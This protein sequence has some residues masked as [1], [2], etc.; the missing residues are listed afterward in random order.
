MA[1]ILSTTEEALAYL[2]VLTEN[3]EADKKII[4]SGELSKIDI[5]IEGP[6]Y[7]STIPGELARA[8]WEYQEAIY[9]AGAFVLTGSDD[10]RRLSAKQR[11]GLELIFKVEHGS[12]DIQALLEKV[13]E[14]LGEG[15]QQMDDANKAMVLIAITVIFAAGFIAWK[16][17]SATADVR[18]ER[19]KADLDIRNEAEK[20]KQFEVFARVAA[21]E[22]VQRIEKAAEDGTKAVLRSATDATQIAVGRVRLDSDELATLNQR[23]ARV[24]S[25]ADVIEEEFRIFGTETRFEGATRYVLARGDGTEFPVT[26]SHDELSADDLERLWSAARDRQPIRLEVSITKNRDVVK[27]AQIVSVL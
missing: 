19:I 8:L 5:D 27:A 16:A 21:N 26:I 22:K 18:K 6:R 15:F 12:T 11:E 13:V 24:S 20:T 10:I 7:D 17:I 25:T 9:K 23:A 2:V 4:F 1:V 3:S 14:T